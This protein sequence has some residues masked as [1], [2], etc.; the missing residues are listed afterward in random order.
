[1]SVIERLK[2]IKLNSQP[3]NNKNVKYKGSWINMNTFEIDLDLL[4]FNPYN[5]RIVSDTQEYSQIH[6]LADFTDLDKEKQQT[7]IE[8]ILWNKFKAKNKKTEKDI[9]LNGQIEPGVVTSDGLVVDGNRRFMI[10]RRILDKKGIRMPF[11]A[12]ILDEKYTD[13]P[14]AAR[15]IKMLETGI[16]LG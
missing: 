12:V 5:T 1:M 2:E 16:Q 4:E 15:D 8:S 14:Q 3:K 10:L 7:E 13:N 9:L 6:M 11:N